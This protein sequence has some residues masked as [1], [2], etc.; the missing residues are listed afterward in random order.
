MWTYNVNNQ[1]LEDRTIEVI[2]SEEQHR[3]KNNGE[4]WTGPQRC[5]ECYQVYQ[6]IHRGSPKRKEEKGAGKK[7]EKKN[8][9][10]F[11]I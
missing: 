5:A 2:Q 6:N 8:A 7:I 1:Q 10:T 11:Q 4:R 3:R 9:K